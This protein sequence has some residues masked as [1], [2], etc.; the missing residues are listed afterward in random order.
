LNTSQLITRKQS[1]EL[2]LENSQPK[3]RNSKSAGYVTILLALTTPLILIGM[4]WIFHRTGF[5]MRTQ[6]DLKICR[7]ILTQTQA[8]VG[9]NISLLL[10]TNPKMKILKVQKFITL[11]ALATAV[12]AQQYALIP[13]LK[14][15]LRTIE[16]QRK[17]LKLVQKG[18]VDSSRQLMILGTTLA[19]KK[20]LGRTENLIQS[21][22]VI[23]MSP[24]KPSL[25]VEVSN[26]GDS[27]TEYKIKSNFTEHQKLV[28]KW[29]LQSLK[30]QS[31]LVEHQPEQIRKRIECGV[32]LKQKLSSFSPILH[33][34]K[35]F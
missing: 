13:P 7:E 2:K 27:F 8:Q 20:I 15:K 1:S 29:Q 14:Q 16:L 35:F 5:L 31:S 21:L 24:H 11:A 19:Q 34:G 18:L 4:G 32:S 10:L 12:A 6:N 33:Q 28:L 23:S 9:K 22:E 25:A 3:I 30:K 17:S 26:P